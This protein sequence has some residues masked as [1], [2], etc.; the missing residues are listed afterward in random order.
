M[1]DHTISCILTAA[2]TN[3]HSHTEDWRSSHMQRSSKDPKRV[4]AQYRASSQDGTEQ[5]R[6]RECVCTFAYGRCV[7]VYRGFGVRFMPVRTT[8]YG[9]GRCR[10]GDLCLLAVSRVVYELIEECLWRGNARKLPGVQQCGRPVSH[11]A[12]KLRAEVLG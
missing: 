1:R 11:F 10:R 7:C 2:Q 4:H 9:W 5:C 6:S 3:L 12:E 8:C